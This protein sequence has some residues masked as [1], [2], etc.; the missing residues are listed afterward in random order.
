MNFE[1]AM[2]E[3]R[4]ESVPSWAMEK[5]L[6]GMRSSQAPSRA[7]WVAAWAIP[8][9]ATAA[10]LGIA[11]WPASKADGAWAAAMRNLKDAKCLHIR[12]VKELET[13]DV[14]RKGDKIRRSSGPWEVRYNRKIVTS[15]M[16]FVSSTE[17]PSSQEL[18]GVYFGMD[19]FALDMAETK[20]EGKTA[21]PEPRTIDGKRLD[22]YT[23]ECGEV[24]TAPSDEATAKRDGFKR[25]RI[26]ANMVTAYVDPSTN[27]IVKLEQRLEYAPG[28]SQQLRRGPRL[29]DFEAT[30]DYPADLP[31]S[32][33]D[34]PDDAFDQKEARKTVDRLLAG[35]IAEATVAGHT[36]A[37][38]GLFFDGNNL[39]AIWKGCPGDYD[40][41]IRFKVDGKDYGPLSPHFQTNVRCLS[42]AK[43]KQPQSAA[44]P[45][46][47]MGE[48]VTENLPQTVQLTLPVFAPDPGRPFLTRSGK[49][50][51]FHS[52]W[53]GE[54]VFNNVPV[55]RCMALDWYERDLGLLRHMW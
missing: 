7:P 50:L 32:M 45:F 12:F 48:T 10:I 33:F 6:R 38:N 43:C 17:T 23:F 44:C 28:L 26:G 2:E 42:S 18:N 21:K 53:V 20:I 4:N 1:K 47:A 39:Y 41:P 11:F 29:D 24:S 16:G 27:H 14:W 46:S 51:G 5:T 31:D 35:K 30:L 34:P 19:L 54:A 22:A 9:L 3:L 13:V 37:L 36:I 52:K 25:V 49:V 8:V 55:T 40:S 15:K